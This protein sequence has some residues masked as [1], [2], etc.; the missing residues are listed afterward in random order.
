MK[1]Q[2][3]ARQKGHRRKEREKERGKER[4]RKGWVSIIRLRPAE[5]GVGSV[6]EKKDNV[7]G[8]VFC[9]SSFEDHHFSLK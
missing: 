6:L 4:R 5:A 7:L 8:E 9:F 1:H 3:P 2:P